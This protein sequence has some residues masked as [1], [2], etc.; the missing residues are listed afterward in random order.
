MF[1]KGWYYVAKIAIHYKNLVW[2]IVAELL[3]G[4][5]ETSPRGLLIDGHII[6]GKQSMANIFNKTK[7]FMSTG[8][9]LAQW[10]LCATPSSPPKNPSES[11]SLNFQFF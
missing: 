11:L 6:T 9:D 4:R 8:Q 7:Y 1:Y 2:W 5:F 10:L 3:P